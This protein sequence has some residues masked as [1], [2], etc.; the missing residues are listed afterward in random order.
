MEQRLELIATLEHI[1]L[2]KVQEADLIVLQEH[3]HLLDHHLEHYVLLA[4]TQILVL[5]ADPYDLLVESV[6]LED[7]QAELHEPMVQFQTV[8]QQ[9]EIFDRL[10]HIHKLDGQHDKIE[11][12]AII[13][14]QMQA[15]V[16]NVLEVIFEIKI[17][18]HLDQNV[19]LVL[20]HRLI[21]LLVKYDLQAHLQVVVLHY[22]Q[23]VQSTLTQ[24]QMRQVERYETL[25]FT[26]LQAPQHA[27]RF[28]EMGSE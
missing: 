23:L 19:L 7:D 18:E 16:F 10:E 1:L 22:A 8:Q 15:V 28:E 24:D 12:R 6:L 20:T 25:D 3:F 5:R 2:L 11:L 17:N 9:L 26:V 13:R 14:V 27:T 21:L 4:N